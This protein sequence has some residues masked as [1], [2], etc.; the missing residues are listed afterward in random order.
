MTNYEVWQR[1]QDEVGRRGPD[2]CAVNW[3]GSGNRRLA[4]RRR[5]S[6][7]P[8]GLSLAWW[9]KEALPWGGTACSSAGWSE[10][11]YGLNAIGATVGDLHGL[12]PRLRSV[13]RANKVEKL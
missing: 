7:A 13:L 8:P 11:Y 2:P 12:A 4:P 1:L 5:F 3:Q 6:V 10:V 9:L